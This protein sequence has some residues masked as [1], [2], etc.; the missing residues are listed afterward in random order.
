MGDGS[1]RARGGVGVLMGG[2][3]GANGDVTC[4]MT[5]TV[6]LQSKRTILLLLPDVSSP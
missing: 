2:D 6:T 1:V 5:M 4:F 3:Y